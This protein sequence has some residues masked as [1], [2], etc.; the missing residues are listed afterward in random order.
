MSA[1]PV[2]ESCDNC[3]ACCRRTPVPPFQ[4]GEEAERDIPEAWLQPVKERIAADQHFDLL[5]CVW[6]DSQTLRCL[7][8]EHRPKACCDFE[9]GSDLCRI[10]RW[11][12]GVESP[13]R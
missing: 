5:P 8:Y 3:A 1:L 7:H 10:S 2:I 4:P 6:L 13:D 11:D 12:E 9:I